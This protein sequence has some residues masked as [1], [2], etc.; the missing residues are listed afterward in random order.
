MV[1]FTKMRLRLRKV[2]Q[3]LFCPGNALPGVLHDFQAY[4]NSEQLRRL[5]F[6]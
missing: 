1:R 6:K 3:F 2:F 4:W 5:H